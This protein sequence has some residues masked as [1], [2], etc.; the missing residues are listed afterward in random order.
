MRTLVLF[1]CI[2]F[3]AFSQSFMFDRSI[4]HVKRGV[5]DSQS[6]HTLQ[7]MSWAQSAFI[8]TAL[9]GGH[10]GQGFNPLPY[11]P[12]ERAK[13]ERLQKDSSSKDAAAAMKEHIIAFLGDNDVYRRIVQVQNASNHFSMFHKVWRIGSYSDPIAG[14]G[15]RIEFSFFKNRAHFMGA[16][17]H[18]NGNSS[19]YGSLR[20]S[21]SFRR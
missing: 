11:T 4:E 6:L 15:P 1:C 18:G 20:F 8:L 12:T 5:L 10:Y 7:N 16:A 2:S 9:P 19:V 14:F 17:A 13:T 3:Q 21:P